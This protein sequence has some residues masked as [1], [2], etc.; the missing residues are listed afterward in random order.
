MMTRTLK[1]EL[2]RNLVLSC[3]VLSCFGQ[4]VEETSDKAKKSSMKRR[5]FVS[6]AAVWTGW[7][8][9]FGLEVLVVPSV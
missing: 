6:R 5:C 4:V 3:P 8:D 9:G 7:L 2:L 1:N